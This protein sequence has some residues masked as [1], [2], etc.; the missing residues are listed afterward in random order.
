MSYINKM[1][2]QTKQVSK[3]TKT[4]KKVKEEHIE[5]EVEEV[6]DTENEEEETSEQEDNSEQ[7][8]EEEVNEEEEVETT[9]TK[10]KEKKKKLTTRE[11]YSDIN[12][13]FSELSK[14]ETDWHEKEKEHEKQSKEFHS[15]R[16]KLIHT[17]EATLKKFE[18]TFTS[19]IGKPKKPRKTENA[20]K[21]GFNKKAEIP[22]ILRDYIGIKGDELMSRPEVTKLLNQKFT[23][24]NLMK[25]KKDENGK[26]TKV[27]VLDKATAKKL[28][29]TENEE[30]RNRGIQTFIAKFYKDHKATQETA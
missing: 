21:G 4:D 25:V 3:S 27:I 12:G 20:G 1:P 23:E 18:K 14:L 13:L 22:P 29:C 7:E 24:S 11:V 8:S 26:D 6:N 28:K 10:E 15:Q 2:K 5:S 16:K 17:I 19:E 30:I 9:E